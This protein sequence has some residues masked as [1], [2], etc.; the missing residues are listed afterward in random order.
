MAVMA[1]LGRTHAARD[2]LMIS[3]ASASSIKQIAAGG[4]SRRRESEG[5]INVR[6]LKPGRYEFYDDFNEKARGALNVQ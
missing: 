6:P 2:Y 5:V 1:A 3:L 4:K